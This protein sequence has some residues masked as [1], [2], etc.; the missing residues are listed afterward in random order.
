MRQKRF[1]PYFCTQFLGAFN[2]NV[3]KNALAILIGYVL[4]IENRAILQNIA[5][6]A[7]ILPYFL[8]GS[9]AG[10]LADKFE[11]AWLIRRIKLAEV[12]IMLLGCY[13]LYLQS[14]EF[15]LFVLFLLG[16]QSAFFG[17]IKYSIL[18]QHIKKTELLSATGYVQA[19]TFTSILL[20]TILGGFLVGG[21]DTLFPLMIGMVSIAVLGYFAAQG[22]PTAPPAAPQLKVSLNVWRST[23]DIMR[24]TRGNRPVFLS[25][26]A[27]SWLWFFGSIV[28]TQFPTF[29]AEIL[30]GNWASATLLLATF[31][32]GIAIGAL[33]C[34]LLS[35]G[36]V[37]LGLLPIG[38]IGMSFF[39]WQISNTAL[40][41][42]AELRTLAELLAVKGS[43]LM[44]FNMT[45]MAVSS[46]L[47]ITPLYAFMQLRSDEQQ[48]SRVVAVNN[49]LNS[50]FMVLAGGLAAGMLALGF[51]V[52]DVFK[53]AALLNL[54]VAL[55]ILYLIP[56]FFLRLLSWLMVHCVYRIKKQDLQHIPEEGA[57]LLVCNHV[58]FID[59]MI[60][61][62]L[63]P[64]P[65]R[66]VMFYS[67]YELPV[68][69]TLFKALN[70]I[71][72]APKKDAPEV[73]EKARNDI[74][75]SL[76]EGH[77]VVI[78]PEGG[79][80]RNGEIARFQPGI[81]EILK[82]NPVPVIP[83]ALRGVWGIW[84][85]RHKGRALKG[86][87]KAFMKKI[88]LVAGPAVSPDHANRLAMHAKVAELR[89]DER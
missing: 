49:I 69:K 86:I 36:R 42:V 81:D 15:L 7:F 3:F 67:F 51:S 61:L 54:L 39:T 18:P 29:A 56:E 76:N 50:I 84:F 10:Q 88:S 37:E 38:A 11:K 35:G 46:G 16:T 41:P 30:Y 85:S 24:M 27:I 31:T 6:I 45:M 33:S 70:S 12:V 13:A 34:A 66:F 40:P 19:G 28:L 57:A 83:L 17:P 20:G 68:M 78:F 44:I 63:A 4:I 60:I 58:S 26:L 65:A 47:F 64:R 25:I 73:L 62:A 87:P 79:I 22:I 8:F 53:V 74:S 77:L 55:I 43:W 72:I 21:G 82:R 89:G 23:I 59:P 14:I 52:L 32:V 9:T 2:D 1:L 5:L 48:R 71:P 80:T 75:Q